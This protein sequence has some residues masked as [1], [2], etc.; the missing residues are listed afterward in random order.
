M[1]SKRKAKTVRVD[2]SATERPWRIAEILS[3]IALTVSIASGVVSFLSYQAQFA[4]KLRVDYLPTESENYLF[5]YAS[6][7][8]RGAAAYLRSIGGWYL[9]RIANISSHPVSIIEIKARER[10]GG[11]QNW[12]DLPTPLVEDLRISADAMK[13]KSFLDLPLRMDVDDS[14]KLYAFIPLSVSKELGKHLFA[15]LRQ[16]NHPITNPT[17]R[18]L[19]DPDYFDGFEKRVT[20]ELRSAKIGQYVHIDQ[21]T[22][23]RIGIDRPPFMRDAEG[24]W[25]LRDANNNYND[26]FQY[27]DALS[28]YNAVND[29]ILDSKNEKIDIQ[30]SPSESVELAFY[31][32]GGSI[33]NITLNRDAMA[34]NR[35]KQQ[36]NG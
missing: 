4:E 9:F 18:A 3:G 11:E 28:T 2:E 36:P 5:P 19:L 8:E 7:R 21:I 27:R 15:L 31:L 30:H 32:A 26:G 29:I 34:L 16:P 1:A 24:N 35:L 13:A 25:V 23:P 20:E 12:S 10:G 6:E 14:K 17:E 33:I 22:M